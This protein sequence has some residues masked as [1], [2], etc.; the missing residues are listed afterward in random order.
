MDKEQF[1]R[2]RDAY[3]STVNNFKAGINPLST[4]PKKF[5]RSKAFKS[6]LKETDPFV[7]GSSAPDIKDFLQPKLGMNCL[8]VGC[9]A[10]LATKRFDKWPSTYC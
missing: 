6:F 7:T 2:I 9:C 10:N 8:D 1:N 3:D 5:K 4:V